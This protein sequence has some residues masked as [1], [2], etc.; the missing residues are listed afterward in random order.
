MAHEPGFEELARQAVGDKATAKTLR[1]KILCTKA[2]D[3]LAAYGEYVHG[4]KPAPHQLVW[5]NCLE[6]LATAIE[7]REDPDRIEELQANL[8]IVAPPGHGKTNW[9]IYFCCWFLGRNPH[10]HIG[11]VSNTATLAQN[12]SL[13]V[14]DTIASSPEHHQVFPDSIPNRTKVWSVEEWFLSRPQIS[15]KNP[16]FTAVGIQ[17][18]IIGK[19]FDLII[20]D[21]VCDENNMATEIQREKVRTYLAKTVFSRLTPGGG[22]CSIMTRWHEDDAMRLLKDDG[23]FNIVHMP[24]IGF[25][26]MWEGQELSDTI[27]DGSAL[28]E[29][30]FPKTK[31]LQI[32]R[33]DPKTFD[34]MYQG[35]ESI[36]G[37]Q[38]YSPKY[39]NYYDDPPLRHDMVS[40][41]Q[42]VDP[43]F[44]EDGSDYT[45]IATWCATQT[46]AYLLD[47]YRQRLKFLDLIYMIKV[48]YREFLPHEVWIEDIGSGK[49]ALQTIQATT[50][51]PVQGY[52][53]NSK[54]KEVHARVGSGL[55]QAGLVYLPSEA[56]WLR[57]FINEHGI[58]PNG[59]FDDM[60]DTTSM[61]LTI[62]QNIP[63]FEDGDELMID[64]APG[65]QELLP[66]IGEEF[67]EAEIVD[68]GF[69]YF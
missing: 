16:T 3:S 62:L 33:R 50:R 21:D 44:G 46:G 2:R 19:R 45:V 11:Y 25:W 7:Q 42:T 18:S 13:A 8:A 63:L 68:I 31:L 56:T 30:Y 59:K 22:I 47:I 9:L 10:L 43:A 39:W 57:E 48:K 23:T 65:M 34:L 1:G 58:F 17:G 60:V 24:A 26:E 38:Y 5:I 52:P 66:D 36:E 53:I 69:G 41:I 67:V 12:A 6:R 14:R 27:R 37:G 54:S 32:R 20:L 29:S 55:C 64:Y 4:M 51:I 49:S 40:I 15:D 61:A 28:W 35:L